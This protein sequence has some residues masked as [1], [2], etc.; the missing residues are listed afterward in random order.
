M[1]WL[2]LASAL[3]AGELVIEARI[4]AEV[5]VDGVPHVQLFQPGEVRLDVA[6]G[7]RRVTLITGSDPFDVDVQ[8]PAAGHAVIVVGRTGVT[9][10]QVAPPPPASEDVPAELR[11]AGLDDL[12]LVLDGDRHALASGSV[13]ALTLS[14]G[15]HPLS[16]R[17]RDGT[18]VWA[19][20]VLH[21]TGGTPIILQL[22]EGLMPE[23]ARG[24]ATFAPDQ[25]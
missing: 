9:T 20:G 24:D 25:Q 23:V 6:E 3:Y 10:G 8:V 12:M 21:I 4:P 11:V 5:Y 7:E 2:T 17:S 15:E 19:R 16:L 13:T 18:L 14:R 22:S 1:L